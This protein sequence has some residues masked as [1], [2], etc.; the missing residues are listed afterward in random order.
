MAVATNTKP[1]RL[2]SRRLTIGFALASLVL[3]AVALYRTNH[4]PRTDDAAVFANFI[5]IAPQVD[6]PVIR[7]NVQDNQFVKKGELLYEVDDRPYQYARETAISNQ[8]PLE[9][10]MVT[11]QR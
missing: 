8:R 2:L 4:Y 1:Q 11:D 7:L 3:G 5:G 10:Q 6:G 9:G